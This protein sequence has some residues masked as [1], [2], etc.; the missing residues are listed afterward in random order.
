MVSIII[1]TLNEEGYL[2]LL[3]E[4]IKKQN[5][6]DCEIIVADADSK[7]TTLDI[8]KRYGC[9]IVPGGLPAKGRNNGA[10]AAKGELLFFLDADTVLPAHFFEK[11]LPEFNARKLSIASFCLRP[12]PE[13]RFEYFLI[14]IFYNRMIIALERVLAHSAM[15]VLIKKEL[16]EKINGYDETIKLAEDHDLGRRAARCGKFGI[17]KSVD[18]LISTRRFSKDS[19]LI[20]GAKFFLCQ[21]HMIFIGPVRSNIFNY[22]FNHYKK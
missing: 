2:P 7:D 3:L 9:N 4:S 20:T 5:L 14:N 18:I 16:F 12:Y 21:L 8:A 11:S 6:Q 17:I 10:K 15:G 1:P 19:W 22:K 13:N